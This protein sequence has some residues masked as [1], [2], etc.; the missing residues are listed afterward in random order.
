MAILDDLKKYNFNF[1]KKFGQNF[2]FDTNLLTSIVN[3]ANLDNS[4][5]VLEIGTGAGTLTNIIS[6]NVKRVV[7]FE[8]DNTLK[9]YLQDKFGNTSNVEIIFED[10][11]NVPTSEIEKKFNGV[12]HIIANL[13]YYITTPIIF[14]FLEESTRLKTLTIMVQQ[15][16]ADRLVAQENTE[17]YGA[18]TAS[19]ATIG[20]AKII[21][22]IN[23]KMF[24]PAPNV[25]SAIVQITLDY[26]KYEIKDRNILKRLIKSGFA[27]RRKTLANNL[28]QAF[29]LTSEQ[30]KELLANNNFDQNVRG[31]A[32]SSSDYVKLAN[33][34]TENF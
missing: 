5:E 14:K 32:L 6:Q 28:K 13:P 26:N 21:K 18:I 34:I 27:M 16:V 20:T 7:S 8:I 11:L 25:D 19:I 23:R 2:I 29:N 4:C 22:K 31:E 24:T 30:I 9:E 15:E 3:S 17:N 1:S 10:V 12:Y 33:Y